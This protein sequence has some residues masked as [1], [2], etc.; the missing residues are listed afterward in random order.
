MRVALV[1]PPFGGKSTLFSAIAH[2]GPAGA[3]TERA[4]QER[5]AMV[6]VPDER[7]LW[8]E[9]VYKPKKRVHAEIGFL[10]VPGLDLSTESARERARA[11]WPAVR[12]SDA[13]V[14]VLRNF[15]NPSVPAYRDRVDYQADLAEIKDEMLFSD[16]AQVASRIEKV[17]A[18]LKKPSQL[19]EQYQKE[20]E[21]FRK[22]QETLE[23]ERP[24]SE[25][26]TNPAD[27]KI[28]RAFAFL[29]LKTAI[30]VVNC[31][32]GQ[33]PAEPPAE[34]A[35]L[36]AIFLCAKIEEEVAALDEADR[37]EF[38]K[39]LGVVEPV[40]D[41][42][43]RSAY[44]A[45]KL[46]SFLTAGEDEVRAWTIPAGTT[47]VNAAGAIHT[48]ISRGFIRAELVGYDDLKAAGTEKAAKAAGK[49]RL[50]GKTYIVQDGD[51]VEFRFN[52]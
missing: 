9:Q 7:L 29:T 33:V 50:E 43:I 44:K 41:R 30:V 25:A 11:H 42:L 3:R 22:L 31:S 18:A 2:S 24:L 19:R 26:I 5:L 40:R 34:I 39:E 38:M 37:A 16:L 28:V 45:M 17:E 27:D 47:A 13:V 8:L 12:Q 52:V 46:I 35:G 4:D 23:N 20:L 36:P 14:I 48:D 49:F 1:G 6:K 21:L 15:D 10:D 51:V 32:E